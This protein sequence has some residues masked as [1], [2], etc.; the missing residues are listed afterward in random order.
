MFDG[1]SP[2]GAPGELRAGGSGRDSLTLAV[3]AESLEVQGQGGSP[4]VGLQEPVQDP[5]AGRERVKRSRGGGGRGG[6]RRGGPGPY[7]FLP[8]S[9]KP[10]AKGFL[11]IFS[12]VICRVKAKGSHRGAG[13][14]GTPGAPGASGLSIP[15]APGTCWFW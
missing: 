5:P 6:R 13:R 1:L 14:A 2:R 7:L 15:P 11:S 3:G 9:R 12:F 4:G 10:L 8:G